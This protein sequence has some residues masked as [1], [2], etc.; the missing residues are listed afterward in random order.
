LKEENKIVYGFPYFQQQ[1]KKY[2]ALTKQPRTFLIISQGTIGKKLSEFIW[3]CKEVFLD[4][5][6]TFKLHPG[7]YERWKTDYPELVK[8]SEL[9]NFTVIDNS[10]TNLYKFMAESEYAIGVYSTAV[11]EA[12]SFDCKV[13]L[14]DLPGIEYLEDLINKDFVKRLKSKSDLEDQLQNGTFKKFDSKLFFA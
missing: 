6:V 4:Y 13:L 1:K 8:L 5:Q 12:L 14:V 2:D 9:E 10:N 3:D 7:E 11:Y